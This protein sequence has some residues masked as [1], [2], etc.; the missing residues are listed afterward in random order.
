M[1][2]MQ[3]A[4]GRVLIRK[5]PKYIA[6][7]RR[8]ASIL[9]RHFR[10]ITALRVTE[11]GP[12]ILHSYYR[13]YVYVRPDK[14]KNEW[15]RDRIIEALIEEGIPGHSGACGE[16]YLEKAFQA[17]GLQPPERM[18]VA[19]KLGAESLMFV[20]HPALSESDM[21]DMCRAT[22]KVMTMATR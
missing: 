14:L 12:E 4:L 19:S 3:A 7:R 17:A 21:E 8:N 22:S 13:Y 20:V 9:A 15:S 6:I 5:I 1:T 2:E 11:P 18:P 16:I 10:T